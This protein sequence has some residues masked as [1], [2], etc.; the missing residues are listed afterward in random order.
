MNAEMSFWFSTTIENF[1]YLDGVNA[2][3]T[4]LFILKQFILDFL[5]SFFLFIIGLMPNLFWICRFSF[6]CRVS[7]IRTQHLAVTSWLWQT[8]W[9]IVRGSICIKVWNLPGIGSFNFKL[10]RR[11]RHRFRRNVVTRNRPTSSKQRRH[12]VF[13]VTEKQKKD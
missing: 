11:R 6:F 10:L 2:G 13:D 8:C 9:L 3:T 1:S 5:F 7:R 4:N 12:I